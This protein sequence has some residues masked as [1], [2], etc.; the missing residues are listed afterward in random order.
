MARSVLVVDDNEYFR[1]IAVKI[2]KSWGHVVVGEATGAEEAMARALE[3]RADTVIADIGLKDADGFEL[4]GL[5][6][7]VADLPL[8]VELRVTTASRR[9]AARSRSRARRARARRSTRP[10]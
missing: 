8:E 3:L 2:I 7:P 5:E 9:R 6:S 4:A 1:A 10:S